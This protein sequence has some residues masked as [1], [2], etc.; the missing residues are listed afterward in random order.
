MY[1]AVTQNIGTVERETQFSIYLSGYEKTVT[2][3]L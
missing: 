3:Q 1:L 2:V